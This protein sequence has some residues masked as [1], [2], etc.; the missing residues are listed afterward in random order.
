MGDGDM[1]GRT[2]TPETIYLWHKQGCKVL[3][4]APYLRGVKRNCLIELEDGKRTVVP[5]RALRREK[6]V[7][8]DESRR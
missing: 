6:G 1:N 4:R 2:E 8:L 5:C 7:E 3:V